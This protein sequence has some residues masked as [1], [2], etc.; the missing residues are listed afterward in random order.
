MPIIFLSRRR[1]ETF[2]PLQKTAYT[3]SA[4]KVT[5]QRIP[6]VSHTSLGV[7]VQKEWCQMV[8]R[9]QCHT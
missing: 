7:C 5:T 9:N 4:K 2:P 6:Y 1:Q 3:I 8:I